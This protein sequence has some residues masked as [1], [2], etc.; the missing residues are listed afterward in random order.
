[1]AATHRIGFVD[2]DLNNFHANVFLKHLRNELADRGFELAG[3]TA[4]LKAEGKQWAEANDVQWFDSVDAMDDS[5]D[6]YMILAPGDPQLHLQLAE[7]V[8]PKGKPTYIDK[9]FSPDLA[10]AERIF[11]LAD[12]HG[13][14][15][16]STSVLRYTNVQKHVAEAG[17][18]NVRHMITWGGGRSFDEYAIHPLELLVSCMGSEVIHLMRRGDERCSQLLL[19]L[20][21]DRTAVVNVFVETATPF[22]ASVTTAEATTFVEVDS[23]QLFL[24][25]LAAILDFLETGKPNI[26]RAETL[27]IR[28]LLDLAESPDA[29]AGFIPVSE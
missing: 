29:A 20:T 27:M 28:R 1:M 10:T 5:V 12:E 26:P 21:D 2:H 11:K 4:L 14:P 19:N 15:V 25:G 18:S 22:A 24:N 9:T 7:A 23:S 13:S 8:L 17:Q 6:A 16:Q 3:C